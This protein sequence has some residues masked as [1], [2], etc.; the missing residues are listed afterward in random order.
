MKAA[1]SAEVAGVPRHLPRSYVWRASGVRLPN[2]RPWLAEITGRDSRFGYTR[3]FRKAKVDYREASKDD[4]RGVWFWWTLESGCI[5]ETRHRT[6]DGASVHRFLRVTDDGDVA[7][8]TAGE[9]E[10]WL[11][12]ASGSTS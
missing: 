2:E 8:M 12:T 4:A 9:V 11:N 7:D 10:Q 5:Y 3:A 6:R 1:F